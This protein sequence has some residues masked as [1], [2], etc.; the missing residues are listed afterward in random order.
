MTPQFFIARRYLRAKRQ[1]GLVTLISVIAA[2]GVT[3]G[4]AALVVTL[5]VFNGFSGIVT[6]LLVGFD[7]H[8]RVEG[9]DGRPLQNPERIVS[10]VIENNTVQG[11]APYAAG[12]LLAVA[13]NRAK[14]I[15]VRGVDDRIGAVSGVRETITVGAFDVSDTGEIRH[16]VMGAI[17]ADRLG[18]MVDDTV[19]LVSPVGLEASLSQLAQPLTMRFRLA[20]TYASLN[21][22]YDGYYAYVGLHSAQR[23]FDVEGAAN[24]VEA[25]L[26]DFEQADAVRDQLQRSFD[27]SGD[28]VR[29]STWYDLHRDLYS[30]MA[31]ERRV[32]FILLSLIIV[33]AGFTIL[34]SLTM[35]VIE[36]Q[37]DISLLKAVGATDR[38]VGR[39]FLYAG[40]LVGVVG[41][42]AGSALGYVVC[43]M[44]QTFHFFT[45][46]S[47]VYIIGALP[48]E[49]HVMDF[50]TVGAAAIVL[51]TLAALYPSRR[52]ARVAP[53]EGL[54]WE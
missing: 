35:T 21:K 22:E 28:T 47:S 5:A 13:G 50:L 49:M 32:A 20:G 45:L 44:Q 46:N 53:A 39:I 10:R 6:G 8:I 43:W 25:R 19:T 11:A 1:V 3:V 7:P 36:K 2:A 48:V 23:L 12:R 31:M 40:A 52:A 24:G 9:R 26:D 29:V 17:L 38:E 51:S 34:G 18:L 33:V 14:V 16:I 42:V 41:T 27:A 54:R 37:R 30:V 4:V 15:T